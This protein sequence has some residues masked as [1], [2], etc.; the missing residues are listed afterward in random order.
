M[1]VRWSARS[2]ADFESILDLESQL[3]SLPLHRHSERINDA[4]EQLR[5]FPF[6]GLRNDALHVRIY[7]VPGTAYSIYYRPVEFQ[8][9]LVTIRHGAQAPL[10]HL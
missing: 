5:I 7:A 3:D 2:V 9:E 1:H 10:A 4:I 6:S 8:I